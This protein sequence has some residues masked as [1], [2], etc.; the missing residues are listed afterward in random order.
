[1]AFY[2]T[3]SQAGTVV[4]THHY[5]NQ[6]YASLSCRVAQVAPAAVWIVDCDVTHNIG[7]TT[8]LGGTY[9]CSTNRLAAFGS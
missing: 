6:F 3:V 5:I 4:A 8:S 1:M 2:C 7:C 9:S